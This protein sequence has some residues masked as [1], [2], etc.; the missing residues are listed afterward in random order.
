MQAAGSG[1]VI[2]EVYKQIPAKEMEALIGQ[3]ERARKHQ[4]NGREGVHHVQK[5]DHL[6]LK[7]W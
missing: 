5:G 7:T 3:D 1:S 4:R 2:V 6:Q